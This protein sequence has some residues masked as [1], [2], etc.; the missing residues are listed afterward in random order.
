M[1]Y[2]IYYRQ[3]GKSNVKYELKIKFKERKKNEK[4]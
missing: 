2:K 3:E 4:I 1:L